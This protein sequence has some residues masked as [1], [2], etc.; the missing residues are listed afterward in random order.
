MIVLVLPAR[1]PSPFHGETDK[2]VL[3]QLRIHSEQEHCSQQ[4]QAEEGHPEEKEEKR[5][6]RL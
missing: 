3:V 2:P 1:V 5:K 4:Q 6:Y